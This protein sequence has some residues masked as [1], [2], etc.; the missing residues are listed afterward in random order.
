M[1]TLPGSVNPYK[2]GEVV[3]PPSWRKNKDNSVLFLQPLP[4]RTN[5]IKVRLNFMNY[6][7]QNK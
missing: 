2:D 6:F 5:A 3:H 4:T 7:I 1:D